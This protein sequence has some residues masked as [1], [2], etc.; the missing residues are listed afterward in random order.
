MGLSLFDRLQ[1]PDELV[2]RIQDRMKAVIN[3][4]IQKP[5]VDGHLVTATVAPA[6]TAVAHKLGRLPRGYFVVSGQASIIGLSAAADTNFLYVSSSGG[7]ETVT[8]WVF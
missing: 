7:S 3:A 6:Q 8:F 4:V 5:L 1:H 2:N